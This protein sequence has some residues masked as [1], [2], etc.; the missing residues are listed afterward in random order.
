MRKSIG[1]RTLVLVII[2]GIIALLIGMCGI[3]AIQG[4]EEDMQSIINT[5]QKNTE[6]RY[7]EMNQVIQVHAIEELE[8]MTTN[9]TILSALYGIYLVFSLATTLII[10]YTVAKPTKRARIKLRSIIEKLEK[11]EGDLTERLEVK[12]QDEV[13]K[14]S[15]GINS[16]IE[17][18]QEIV[19]VIQKETEGLNTASHN[20][21]KHIQGKDNKTELLIMLNGIA[22]KKSNTES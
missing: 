22:K 1:R 9:R 20:I 18:L 8:V 11:G 21:N 14:L 13:S 2:L 4:A 3:F 7:D 17:K 19:M 5:Y 12:G 6:Y 10:Y 15:Q 16:F